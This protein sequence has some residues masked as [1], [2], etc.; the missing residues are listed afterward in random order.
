MK[1][2]VVTVTNRI[3]TEPYYRFHAWK[4]SLA[5]YGVEPVVLG[6]GERWDGLVTKPRRLLK[7]LR[8]PGQGSDCMIF[9][10]SWDVLFVK[11]P[12]QIAEEWKEMGRPWICGAERAL[13]PPADTSVWPECT[14]P[15]RFLNSGA[16]VSSPEQMLAVLLAM[17]PDKLP[18]DHEKPDGTPFHSNDQEWL[19]QLFLKQ[20]IPMVL[21]TECKLIWNLCDVPRE[22]AHIHGDGSI[23]NADTGTWP[24]I[25]HANGG[26]KEGPIFLEVLKLLNL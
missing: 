14:T 2:N 24:G 7:W 11:S 18:D 1:V 25:L 20:P 10:D 26:A 4:G 19:Q 12:E 3:P 22:S 23:R 17:D 8:G 15:Y 16:I 21:D 5:R 6:L 9:T 13:F